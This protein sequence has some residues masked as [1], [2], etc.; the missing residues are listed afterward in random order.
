MRYF[1]IR[2]QS[3]G[4]DYTIGC[5]ISVEELSADNMEDAIKE[6]IDL[7]D[8]WKSQCE[9]GGEDNFDDNLHEMLADCGLGDILDRNEFRIESGE[10]LE[11]K[12]IVNMMPI[13]KEKLQ[14]VYAFKKE[15]EDKT[16]SDSERALY[17][18][19]HKKYGKKTK[20]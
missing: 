3:G 9:E 17:E 4:C 15:F 8:D 18:K 1:Y 10:I 14:E 11:V 19:L 16:Q 20:K 12:N 13:L 5:G 7:P 6:V 2:R